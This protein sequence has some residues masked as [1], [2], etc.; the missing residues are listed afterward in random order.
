MFKRIFH[1]MRG[2]SDFSAEIDAH[3]QLE[4][5]RLRAQ[6]LSDKEARKTAHRAFGNVTHAQERFHE[7]HGWVW[8]DHIWQDVR[9][10]LRMLR[11]SPSFTLIAAITLALGIGANTA[12]FSV[13]DSFLLRPTPVSHPE[14]IAT[15]AVEQI[16]GTY[17]A[18]FSYPDLQDIRN[19]SSALFSNV[20]ASMD[21]H[22]TDGLSIDGNLQ[23]IWTS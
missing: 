3:I 9:Y 20:S 13:V 7:S 5:E 10:G 19:Q 21:F 17:S 23:P 12:I 16:G 15:L 1:R 18:S 8:L 11:K 14:Q 4:I 6:G 22:L 2:S